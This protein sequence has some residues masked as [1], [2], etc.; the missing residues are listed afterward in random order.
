[1]TNPDLLEALCQW[2]RSVDN[3]MK[4]LPTLDGNINGLRERVERLEMEAEPETPAPLACGVETYGTRQYGGKLGRAQAPAT[5]EPA[6]ERWGVFSLN[7]NRSIHFPGE[8]PSAEAGLAD[9]YS[10]GFTRG[11]YTAK[12]LDPE[13]APV[14][15]PERWGVFNDDDS[16]SSVLNFREFTSSREAH[17]AL[18]YFVPHH[19]QVKRLDD[20]APEPELPDPKCSCE[21]AEGLKRKLKEIRAV[22][23]AECGWCNS[24]KAIDELLMGVGE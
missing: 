13:P 3:A 5:T 15:E 11:A 24:I 12:R 2:F 4:R 9:T 17:D 18:A 6:R 1:M 21:E 7:R 19:F 8:Y 22:V 23:D 20:L 14:S 16:R 10:H